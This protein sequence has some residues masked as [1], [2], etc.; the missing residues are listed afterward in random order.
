VIFLGKNHFDEIY[1]KLHPRLGSRIISQEPLASHT[2]FGIGGPAVLFIYLHNIDELHFSVQ[3]LKD[4]GCPIFVLGGG[5]NLLVSDR[6]FSGAV[7]KLDGD[8][9]FV[10]RQG[11][12]VR[13]GAATSLARTIK[14]VQGWGLDG[15]TFA[16]GI[17]GSVGG[18]IAVNAGAY[19][20]SVGDRL[21]SAV[22]Y[23]IERGTSSVV[24]REDFGFSYRKTILDRSSI[25]LEALFEL[26]EGSPDGVQRKMDILASQRARSQPLGLRTAGCVFKNPEGRFA[27][28][29]IERAGCKGMSMGRT[30]VSDT[31]ANFIVNRGGASAD[32][33]YRLIERVRERVY[34]KE[35]IFLET[36]IVLLGEFGR[37]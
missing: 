23:H 37:G 9:S 8:F 30:V 6:G 31:H 28:E 27:G 4:C 24:A 13:V 3:I 35:A 7:L 22:V 32:E 36:E 33:V 17:P 12:R 21:V 15:L 14:E 10:E 19:G 5:S 18:A 34:E 11:L 26:E 16:V 29:L 20:F 2:S 25:I 1:L